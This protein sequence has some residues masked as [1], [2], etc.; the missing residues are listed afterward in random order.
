MQNAASH[1]AMCR[2][3]ST[4]ESKSATTVCLMTKWRQGAVP[5]ASEEQTYE[6]LGNLRGIQ[7]FYYAT[8][9]YSFMLNTS[10]LLICLAAFAD[11]PQCE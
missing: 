2:S 4:N 1:S 6:L 7:S 3:A 11:T 8:L 9:L 10:R 5:R